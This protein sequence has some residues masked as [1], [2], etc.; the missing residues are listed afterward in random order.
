LLGDAK[1][2][3]VVS[4]ISIWEEEKS[5]LQLLL[6]RWSYIY[7]RTRFVKI[8]QDFKLPTSRWTILQ[9]LSGVWPITSITWSSC[10]SDK[11][12]PASMIISTMDYIMYGS[13][14]FHFILPGVMNYIP[15][16]TQSIVSEP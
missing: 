11:V 12:F 5:L 3:V 6:R 16:F 10:K 4:F 8:D 13:V 1:S 14:S 7:M 2:S 9:D 15:W